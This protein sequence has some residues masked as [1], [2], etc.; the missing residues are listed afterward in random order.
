M[1]TATLSLTWL[2]KL[3]DRSLLLILLLLLLLLLLIMLLFW[4]LFQLLF[5]W[6]CLVLPVHFMDNVLAVSHL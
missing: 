3:H 4:L 5:Y 6:Y 2:G 1:T